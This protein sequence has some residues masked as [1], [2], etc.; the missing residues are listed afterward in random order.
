MCVKEDNAKFEWYFANKQLKDLTIECNS[1]EAAFGS[2]LVCEC[3]AFPRINSREDLEKYDRKGEYKGVPIGANSWSASCKFYMEWEKGYSA[4]VFSANYDPIRLTG[5]YIT[6]T[7]N[8]LTNWLRSWFVN[9]VRLTKVLLILIFSPTDHSCWVRQ[10][11]PTT[12]SPISSTPPPIPIGDCKCPPLKMYSMNDFIS[13]NEG[14]KYLKNQQSWNPT[15][16]VDKDLCTFNVQCDPI[17]GV[18]NYYTVGLR[19]KKEPDLLKVTSCDLPAHQGSLHNSECPDN[20]YPMLHSTDAY[21]T[22]GGARKPEDGFFEE[23]MWV[24]ENDTKFAWYFANK[25]LNSLW[26]ECNSLEAVFGAGSKCECGAFPQIN[27]RIDLENY[28]RKG[29]YK[30]VQIENRDFSTVHNFDMAKPVTKDQNLIAETKFGLDYLNTLSSGNQ[31]SLVFSPLSVSLA[32]SLVHSGAKGE[33]RAEI[34][35]VLLGGADSESFVKYYSNL[36]KSL[37]TAENETEV[38]VANR[39][40]LR[41]TVQINKE[42]LTEIAEN[43]NAGAESLDLENPESAEKINAF[44]RDST[45]GK[46][47]NLVSTDSNSDAVALLVNAI[48]FK[49]KWDEEFEMDLTSPREFTLKSGELMAIPFLREMETD[50]LY[51]S[52]ENFQTLVLNY[53]DASFKFAVFL[54]KVHNGLANAMENLDADK[55]QN[56][57]NSAERTYMNTEIPKFSIE[58]ELNLKETLQTLGI[59]EILS[60]QADLSGIAENIKISDVTHKALVEVNEEGTTAAAA[61]VI[62]AV[63]MCLRMEQPVE[64]KANHPF[65][66]SL[67][68]DGHPLFLGVFHGF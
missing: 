29:E 66:F 53:K 43:Y 67:V 44:I 1:I 62:K 25:Q 9:S 23:L 55:F 37:K 56:L 45:H 39:V 15:I 35:K 27:N 24:K 19:S 41:N 7:Y 5:N 64:F 52:D 49:G 21:I 58:K 26:I 46:L 10:P 60:D 59:T 12:S 16:S 50:R 61:T 6:C 68:R 20:L 36:S 48:Y 38:C 22:T 34:E 14:G 47:D 54:P 28:D 51:S 4:V 31:E 40:F 63:P 30:D 8:P 65:L 13:N 11:K 18:P 32:L 57:L 33:S 17:P 3:G 2:E 42:Y